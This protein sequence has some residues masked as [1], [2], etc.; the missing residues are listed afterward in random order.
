MLI[1]KSKYS[2]GDIVSVRLSTGEEVVGKVA[3][4]TDERLTLERPRQVQYVPTSNGITLLPYI[5][6]VDPDKTL[7][8]N[9]A[10]VIVVTETMKEMKDHYIQ[11]TTGITTVTN[12]KIAL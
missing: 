3:E 12:G 5:F 1:N 9:M 2:V 11:I 6:S 4:T 8:F 7:E 10:H